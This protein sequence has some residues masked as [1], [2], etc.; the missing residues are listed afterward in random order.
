MTF[1]DNHQVA[2]VLMN[3]VETCQQCH[4]ATLD[5]G[6]TPFVD[7]GFLCWRY[8]RV[9]PSANETDNDALLKDWNH[10]SEIQHLN[11]TCARCGNPYSHHIPQVDS[12]WVRKCPSNGPGD[13]FEMQGY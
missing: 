12:N 11:P 10:A 7:D 6:F 3:N 9:K 1:C 4:K 5:E 2:Y 8:T 13:Y